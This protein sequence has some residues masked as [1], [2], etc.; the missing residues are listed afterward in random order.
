MMMAGE[1]FLLLL[2]PSAERGRAHKSFGPWSR[3]VMVRSRTVFPA[4]SA[5]IALSSLLGACTPAS[6][7]TSQEEVAAAVRAELRTLIPHVGTHVMDYR[8]EL[9]LCGNSM[10]GS[11]FRLDISLRFA[12]DAKLLSLMSTGYLAEKEA[13][14]W[15]VRTQ[16][17]LDVQHNVLVA[18]NGL[19]F[20]YE[21]SGSPSSMANGQG[22]C[23]PK[24]AG[25]PTT[26][27]WAS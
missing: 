22:P 25:T 24:S 2:V 3:R 27:G 7:W 21:T 9:S 8:E 5:V 1:R 11:Y 23:L 19:S 16:P 12:A 15:K 13:Q 10:D 17:S 20:L 14:G 6:P 18:P 26:Q 4:L